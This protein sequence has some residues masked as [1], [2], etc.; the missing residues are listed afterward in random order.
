MSTLKATNLSHA[1]AAS[2]NIVLDSAGKV[3]FGG[4]VA[5]AGMDLITPTSVAGTGVTLSGGAVSF[6]TASTVS[7]NGCFTAT[8]AN[9]LIV[10]TFVTTSTDEETF[11]RLRASGTDAITNYDHQYIL[12][13]STT[14]S[15]ARATGATSY[16]I[17][18]GTANTNHNAFSLQTL[19]PNV[20]AATEFIS[21]GYTTGSSGRLEDTV[22]RHTTASAY[23]GFTVIPQNGGS[24]ITGTLRIYGLRNS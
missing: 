10:S 21:N 14:V 19:G 6:T 20:S 23:D 2:P 4:A 1:S 12:A 7:V 9:Y 11:L 22:G 13:S 16:R 24:T 8:Y 18:G 15:A 3:T 17:M 5:G